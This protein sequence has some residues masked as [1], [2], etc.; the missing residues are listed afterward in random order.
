MNDTRV[1]IVAGLCLIA[2]VGSTPARAGSWSAARPIPTPRMAAV[3]G[4]IDGKLYVAGGATANAATPV[5]MPSIVPTVEI[6]DPR[7]G[8]WTAGPPMPVGRMN[9]SSA[10][11]DGKLYVFGGVQADRRYA[12]TTYRF[13]PRTGGW[14][15]LARSPDFPGSGRGH[16]EAEA[17]GE[18][19]FAIGGLGYYSYDPSSDR[20][21]TVKEATIEP[22]PNGWRY[23]L[24]PPQVQF[25][26]EAIEGRI[27]LAGGW[28]GVAA[29]PVATL[30][31]YDPASDSWTS[32][33]SMPT[34]RLGA[35]SGVIDGQLLVAGG[36][37]VWNGPA[38]GTLETYDPST[39]T[40]ATQPD[41]PTPRVSAVSGVV[42]GKLVLVGGMS[43]DRGPGA[44]ALSIVEVF[45]PS[46]DGKAERKFCV[47]HLGRTICIDRRSAFG[48]LSEHA[49]AVGA[50]PS[51]PIQ[52]L[53]DF[54]GRKPA[55]GD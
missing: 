27:F 33:A 12:D 17:I 24:F 16:F 1:S 49:D 44:P 42:D 13:D 14:T 2:V 32:L 39:D 53:R 45:D 52:P 55:R 35:V 38:L 25:T 10:V 34:P 26:S 6:Y 54:F 31:A 29:K 20:W 5:D 50:C 23:V 48:H 40:W 51:G 46:D 15:E 28:D 9:A 11:L 30:D 3:A 41:M 37:G 21:T 36:V 22:L 43:D 19:L 7:R 8:T 4:V 47:C 18:K